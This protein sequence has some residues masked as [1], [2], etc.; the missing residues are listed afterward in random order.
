MN[1]IELKELRERNECR[2]REAIT[3]LG[4]RYVCHPANAPSR[5]EP[6]RSLLVASQ[7]SSRIAP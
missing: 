6:R 7:L 5:L 4:S 2:A 1:D 3:N